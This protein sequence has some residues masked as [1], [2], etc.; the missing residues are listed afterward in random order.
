MVWAVYAFQKGEYVRGRMTSGWYPVVSDFKTEQEAKIWAAREK[1]DSEAGLQYREIKAG[2]QPP[3]EYK[4]YGGDTA[5]DRARAREKQELAEQAAEKLQEGKGISEPERMALI[6]TYKGG[7]A[8]IARAEIRP[9]AIKKLEAGQKLTP[10]ELSTL[11]ELEVLKYKETVKRVRETTKKLKFETAAEARAAGYSV[12]ETK[13]EQTLKKQDVGLIK[14]DLTKPTGGMIREAPPELKQQ[15]I[16]GRYEAGEV[17]ERVGK[18]KVSNLLAV[19]AMAAEKLISTPFNMLGLPETTKLFH[20]PEFYGKLK[21]FYEKTRYGPTPEQKAA[22]QKQIKESQKEGAKGLLFLGGA[23]AAGVIRKTIK[24]P[25]T[26]AIEILGIG[27]ATKYIGDVLKLTKAKT[28]KIDY[29]IKTADIGVA[30]V[31]K[32]IKKAR[33]ETEAKG[34]TAGEKFDIIGTGRAKIWKAEKID[35][36]IA[37]IYKFETLFKEKPIVIEPRTIK[38]KLTPEQYAEQLLKEGDLRSVETLQPKDYLKKE[39]EYG[40][41]GGTSAGFYVTG[42]RRIFI[43]GGLFPSPIT[44]TTVL[45]H[46][47][48]HHLYPKMPHSLVYSKGYSPTK[49]R[50]KKTENVIA[51][52]E[53]K[54]IV[55]DVALKGGAYKVEGG[56]KGY[57]IS[58]ATTGLKTE[59]YITSYYGGKLGKTKTTAT[60]SGLYT[61]GKGGYPKPVSGQITLLKE[62]ATAIPEGYPYKVQ[63]FKAVDVGTTAD[64]MKQYYPSKPAPIPKVRQK[65]AGMFKSKR[66]G[67]LL[68][69]ELKQM[70]SRIMPSRIAP[71]GVIAKGT[72]IGMEKAV[73]SA[74]VSR[75]KPSSS[76]FIP[77]AEERKTADIRNILRTK[78]TIRTT[79]EI[80]PMIDTKI[81]PEI[82]PMIDIRT[83]TDT[84]PA[85]KPIAKTRALTDIRTLTEVKPIAET[86]AIT[87]LQITPVTPTPPPP[88]PIIIPSLLSKL[89][90][91]TGMVTT[92]EQGYDVL[93][94]RKQLKLAKGKYKGR[95]YKKANTE[96]LTRKAALGL[97]ASLVD[98]YTNKSYTIKKAKRNA[99]RRMDLEQKWQ[100]LKDKFRANKN[101]IIEKNKF[102]IDSIEE[103]QGIPYEAARLRKAGLLDLKKR[104]T[105]LSL[106]NQKKKKE[107]SN[108]IKRKKTDS[109]LI[110]KKGKRS[111]K[112]V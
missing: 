56:F 88:P 2:V 90:K 54:P 31:G 29:T 16:I 77:L 21:T 9:E 46:E 101:I 110:R 47:L 58:E 49:F 102:A 78:P 65:A 87:E 22:W 111:N 26:S 79:T 4:E 82:K 45:K 42:T 92:K 89:T 85:V 81:V 63:Y 93:I 53:I 68:G 95:G 66:G 11:G 24:Q 61:K 73:R 13:T 20:E 75:V 23:Y 76:L 38:Q 17:S 59:T 69:Q 32:G 62:Y 41:K 86:R 91:E 43:S 105:I 98:T 36:G 33:I 74:Y 80:K 107:L 27:A 84:K 109:F 57:S 5:A 25:I 60:V 96:P 71:E 108:L 51:L 40:I 30:D 94:K 15:S 106:N 37:G 18:T 12:K 35:Q 52:S 104:K 55:T 48:L 100:R 28:A 10:I 7:K 70:P 8:M 14:T 1:P 97:G 44:S 3:T 112:W 39:I 6:K 83:I 99:V 103:K 19:P 67:L 50:V 34:T 64:V 72:F